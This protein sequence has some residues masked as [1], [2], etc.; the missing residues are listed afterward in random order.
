[1][2]DFPVS[3]FEQ[4]LER[5]Q[6]AMHAENLDALLFTSEAEMRYFTGFRSLFWQSPTRPWFLIVPANGKPVAIIP[7][8]GRALMQSTWIDD[9]RT[10]SSPHAEDDGISLLA[11]GLQD[12]IR[13]GLPMG[14][15]SSLR[16]PLADYQKLQ[17]KL[18]NATFVDASPLIQQLRMVKSETEIEKIATICQIASASFANAAELFHEGQPLNDAFRT[19]KIEL[20]KQGAEEVPYLVGGAGKD[21]YEDVISPASEKPLKSGD[22]LMLDT[23]ATRDG[24]FCDFDRNFALGHG[25]DRANQAYQT[26]YQ[27]TEAALNAARPGIK[28]SQL[29][30]TMANIIAQGG[31]TKDGGDVGR[32]GHGLG[33]QLTEHPSIISF[34]DT[35]LEEGMV[36][37]LE[38]CMNVAGSK[39]MVHE[40]NIVI[41]NGPPQLLSA[42]AAPE[43]PVL[44]E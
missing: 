9:I 33:M 15:E 11:E 24:Y 41:R 34:D 38:P 4:R 36:M 19:F 14:R 35:V 8:I 29:Y 18:R 21:G 42:R 44:G 31:G 1:M 25:S 39:I 3:E 43:L 27:A 37:T 13:I 23:G 16:M 28:C 26:L 5:A 2:A 40:E 7:E 12:C 30:A 6:M 10:W 20:L 32:Y 22:I 17:D